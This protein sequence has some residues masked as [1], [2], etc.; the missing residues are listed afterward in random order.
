MNAEEI[1]TATFAEHEHLAPDA[2]AVLADLQQQL[3]GRRRRSITRSLTTLSA[4]AAVVVLAITVTVIHGTSSP[5]A[6]STQ[7]T[8]LANQTSA[9]T[10]ADMTQ[11]VKLGLISIARQAAVD[12]NGQASSVD[13]VPTTLDAAAQ[14]FADGHD[15][16]FGGLPGSTPVWILQVRGA[17]SHDVNVINILADSDALHTLASSMGSQTS[18][19]LAQFGTVTQLYP[20]PNGQTAGTQNH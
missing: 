18:L 20:D 6:A 9:S 16:H 2:D 1:L 3:A 8:P 17:F 11:A 4:A 10:P 13:A 5:H 7:S 15:L 14:N 12:A 19:D